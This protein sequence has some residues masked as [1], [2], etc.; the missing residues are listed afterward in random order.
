MS[1]FEYVAT[2]VSLV[3]LRRWILAICVAYL[4]LDKIAQNLIPLILGILRCV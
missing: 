4:L 1:E 2:M 3:W